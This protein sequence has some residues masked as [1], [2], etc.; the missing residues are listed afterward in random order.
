LHA[1]ARPPS[2]PT[3]LQPAIPRPVTPPFRR[4]P[5]WL[6]PRIS[7]GKKVLPRR[8]LLRAPREAEEMGLPRG[9]EGK[10]AG[11]G[12]APAWPVTVLGHRPPHH[13]LDDARRRNPG[14]CLSRGD[15]QLHEGAGSRSVFCALGLWRTMRQMPT[16]WNS[17]TRM[18]L[19][20]HV[21][22]G[23]REST[24]DLRVC[25]VWEWR[26]RA[27]KTLLRSGLDRL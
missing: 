15:C 23:R 5:V 11:A 8:E 24:G 6:Q 4:N 12:S 2:S 13:P 9:A 1:S 18:W 20:S 22:V 27:S 19:L 3:W 21:K 26:A 25:Q 16:S 10:T 7:K 17:Y 14:G